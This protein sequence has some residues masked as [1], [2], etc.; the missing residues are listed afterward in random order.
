MNKNVLLVDD[1]HVFNFLSGRLFEKLGF[2]DGIHMAMNGAEAL[3]L[4]NDYYSGTQSLPDVILLDLNMPVMDGF[5]FIEAFQRIRMPNK[6]RVKIVIVSS[7]QDEKDI[8]R[9]R[10][11]GI[12]HYLT[13]PIHEKDLLDIMNSTRWS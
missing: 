12:T 11:L 2:S 6:E 9:A 7:S 3:K 8:E 13:K 4:I 10:T 1:D 5:E